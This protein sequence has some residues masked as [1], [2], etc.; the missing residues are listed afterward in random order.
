MTANAAEFGSTA[1]GALL[2]ALGLT[3]LALGAALT[4]VFAFAAALVVSVMVAGAALA[5]RLWPARP[6]SSRIFDARRTPNGWVVEGGP[7]V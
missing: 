3:A 6:T 7:K 2:R 1:F 4:L 5:M